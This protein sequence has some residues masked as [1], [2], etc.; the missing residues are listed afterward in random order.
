MSDQ[1]TQEIKDAAV[2]APAFAG[3]TAGQAVRL[4][5]G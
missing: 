1:V 4:Y 5:Y 2:V 3:S